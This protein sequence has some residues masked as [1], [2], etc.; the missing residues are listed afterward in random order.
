[1]LVI[2]FREKNIP[3]HEIVCVIP[4]PCYLNWFERY[5]PIVPLNQY[6][7][8]FCLQ[9]ISE[10]QGT[11]PAARQCNRLLYTVVTNINY[12]KSTID[13]DIYIELFT[14]GILSYLT[15]S[16]DNVLNISNDET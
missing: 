7:V 5:Y 2:H 6:Y 14:D 8:P 3:T 15:V 13:H 11:K 4:P 16:T 12:K 10:I 1:M 9:C